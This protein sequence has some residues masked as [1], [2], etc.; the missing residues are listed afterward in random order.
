[1][2]I[3]IILCKFAFQFSNSYVEIVRNA[4]QNSPVSMGK[5]G[6]F[7]KAFEDYGVCFVYDGGVK[8]G[9]IDLGGRFAI[10]PHSFAYD[11]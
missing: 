9:K 7:L 3:Y 10:V 4:K 5:T 2:L 11:R 1:M 6:E 8:A